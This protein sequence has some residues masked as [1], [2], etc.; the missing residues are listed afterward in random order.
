[1]QLSYFFDEGPTHI[2]LHFI[3]TIKLISTF[4]LTGQRV[5][6]E[7]VKGRTN[8]VVPLIYLIIVEV[9]GLELSIESL[10]KG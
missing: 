1:M 3:H 2:L 7:S 8:I 9:Q 5:N 4:P 10:L 6:R